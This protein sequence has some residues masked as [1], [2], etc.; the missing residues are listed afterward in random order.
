MYARKKN[1]L[2]PSKKTPII[3][4]L[5]KQLWLS[6]WIGLWFSVLYT[7]GGALEDQEPP[8]ALLSHMQMNLWEQKSQV[9]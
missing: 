5:T 7:C 4:L 8:F 6:I 1:L 2:A 3:K 9:G